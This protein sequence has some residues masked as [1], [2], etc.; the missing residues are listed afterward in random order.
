MDQL[1]FNLEYPFPL[2]SRDIHKFISRP[3]PCVCFFY[4]S[5]DVRF[6]EIIKIIKILCIKFTEVFCYKLNW[7]SYQRYSQ[8]NKFNNKY[9]ISVWRND[10]KEMTYLCPNFEELEKMFKYVNSMIMGVD[11]NSFLAA[12]DK[13]RHVQQKYDLL[14]RRNNDRYKIKTQKFSRNPKEII[15][16][17]SLVENSQFINLTN[18]NINM[19]KNN[20]FQIIKQD[21]SHNSPKR[22]FSS[23]NLPIHY[24]ENIKI[25]ENKVEEKNKDENETICSI[26]SNFITNSSIHM[27]IKNKEMTNN[28]DI[29][30]KDSNDKISFFNNILD[31]IKCNLNHQRN[32]I[33]YTRNK[34]LIFKKETP[35]YTSNFVSSKRKKTC[36]RKLIS[37]T[38]NIIIQ[39]NNL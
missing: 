6:S 8:H 31:T 22:N 12:L 17:K 32:R 39:K 28:T 36:P 30:I 18:E 20:C 23:K 14:K 26:G 7:E 2:L 13:E 3:C 1:K 33:I 9:E 15:T 5:N 34:Y 16:K 11:N 38:N 35:E 37:L 21:S 10:Q 19:C 25:I 27:T 29:K 24:N 4:E